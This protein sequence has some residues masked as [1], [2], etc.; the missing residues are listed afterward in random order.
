P[1]KDKKVRAV[2]DKAPMARDVVVAKADDAEK[3]NIVAVGNVDA[4]FAKRD[5]NA[6]GATLADDAKWSEQAQPTDW[7]KKECVAKLPKPRARS[8]GT[9]MRTA[10]IVCSPPSRASWSSTMLPGRTRSSTRR[11]TSS[12]GAPFQS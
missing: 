7:T 12:G 11:A 10:A 4:A 8:A 3:A 6:V 9:S 2:L 1:A 5:A